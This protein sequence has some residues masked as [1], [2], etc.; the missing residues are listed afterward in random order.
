MFYSIS[1]I[2]NMVVKR[3]KNFFEALEKKIL[4]SK[5]SIHDN[6]N[7]ILRDLDKELV[8]VTLSYQRIPTRHEFNLTSGQIKR[9]AATLFPM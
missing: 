7:R 2:L 6:F 8:H 5:T 4:K 1:N 9:E 3:M